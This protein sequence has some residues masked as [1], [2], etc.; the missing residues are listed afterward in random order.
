[1]LEEATCRQADGGGGG[2]SP[3][4]PARPHI[5]GCPDV[6]GQATGERAQGPPQ[7]PVPRPCVIGP[8]P[9]NGEDPRRVG[10]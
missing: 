5:P 7:P 4:D 10:G 8:S 6:S 2:L 3:A 9:L 1:M